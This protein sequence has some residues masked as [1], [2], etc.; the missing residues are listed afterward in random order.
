MKRR[1]AQLPEGNN[2]N[3][4]KLKI[5]HDGETFPLENYYS[6]LPNPS[7]LSEIYFVPFLPTIQKE[8]EQEGEN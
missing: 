2:S 8:V 5:F 1:Q 7:L 6:Y 3:L 4:I